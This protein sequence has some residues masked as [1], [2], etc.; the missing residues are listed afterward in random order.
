M[1]GSKRVELD[2]IYVQMISYYV[3]FASNKDIVIAEKGPDYI[4]LEGTG[5]TDLLIKGQRRN[6]N[7]YFRIMGGLEEY[8]DVKEEDEN[9]VVEDIMYMDLIE[10][11]EEE[12][13]GTEEG[14]ND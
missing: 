1:N 14:N 10:R 6:A 5:K 11:E 13:N 9:D 3:A 2:H 8:S 12:Y 7:E 4:L